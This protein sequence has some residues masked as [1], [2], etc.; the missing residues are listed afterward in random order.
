MLLFLDDAGAEWIAGLPSPPI[1]SLS[2]RAFKIQNIDKL[3]I[4]IRVSDP[5]PDPGK[6]VRK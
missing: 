2:G 3:T 6:K 4:S 1:L 5:D